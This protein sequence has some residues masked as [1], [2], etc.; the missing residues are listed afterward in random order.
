[1]DAILLDLKLAVRSLVRAKGFTAA[2]VLALGL[3]IGSACAIFAFCD[4]MLLRPFSFDDSGLAVATANF[5]GGFDRSEIP[6]DV[7]LAWRERAK[8]LEGM[9]FYEWSE[10][11]LTGIDEPEHVLGYRVDPS[12]FS[13]LRVQPLLGRALSPDPHAHEVVLSW[14]LWQRRFGGNPGMV[15]HPVSIDGESFS[16]TGVMPRDFRFPKAGQLWLPLLLTPQDAPSHSVIAV[17]RLAPAAT[18]QSAGREL[19]AIHPQVV[20]DLTRRLPDFTANLFALRDYGDEMARLMLWVLMA[21]VMLLLLIGC[22]NV[23]NMLLARAAGR[24]REIAVRAALGASRGRLL[25]QLLVESALVS[26]LAGAAGLFFAVWG[27]AAIRRMVPPDVSRYIPGWERVGLDARLFS[28]GFAA[29]A[30]TALLSGLAPALYASRLDLHAVLQRESQTAS[31]GRE[32][33]RLRSALLLGETALA[34]VLVF[35]AALLGRSF[36]HRLRMSYGFDPAGV[37]TLRVSPSEARYPDNASLVRFSDEALRRLRQLPGVEAASLV[38]RLPLSGS[39][40]SAW[41]LPEGMPNDAHEARTALY[42]S[43][44]PDCF[45]VLRVPLIAGRGIEPFDAGGSPAVAVLSR[46]L[47]NRLYG[48][49]EAA[50]GHR[51]RTA[52][53]NE[54]PLRTVVGVAGDVRHLDLQDSMSEAVYVPQAQAPDRTMAFMLRT[55]AAPLSLAAGAR[56]EL[57]AI[58]P[59]QPVSEMATLEKV[60]D[61]NVLVG[62]RVTTTLLG[63]F[64]LVAL[65]LTAIGLYG[66]M[67]HSVTQRAREIGIRLALGARP[68]D[69]VRL[70]VRQGTSPVALGLCAGVPLALL[71]ARVLQGLLVEVPAHDPLTFAAVAIFL[72][73]VALAASWAPAR[74]AA[75]TDPAISLRAE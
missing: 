42:Q 23:G 63:T 15:G 9:S 59:D 25:R 4:A 61:D 22:A 51:L 31:M 53:S 73:A 66:V 74:R 12:L 69:V 24:G 32:K 3:G 26:L 39:S 1:M 68:S 37:L 40:R 46:S 65:L 27:I 75:R 43:A 64:A 34:L 49:A 41:V 58:D 28:F 72:C 19:A 13:L 18:L 8:Q 44:A 57:R 21:S 2:A 10:V 55:S 60:V 71:S 45:R 48:S 33:K 5:R 6:A 62:A 14:A 7:A 11:N 35:C 30:L 56:Q 20:R 54:A 52:R 29:A 50:L 38:S 36:A 16:V 70:I 17:A 47:A 67:S